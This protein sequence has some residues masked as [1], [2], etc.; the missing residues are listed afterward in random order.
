MVRSLGDKNL[1]LSIFGKK[2]FISVA[3]RMG[4]LKNCDKIYLISK[5]KITDS[6]NFQKFTNY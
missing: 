4:T 2:T 6:G 3:H 5:G 1:F